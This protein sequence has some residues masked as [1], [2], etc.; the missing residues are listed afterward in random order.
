MKGRDRI[1]KT[2]V[3]EIPDRVPFDGLLPFKSDFFY[4]PLVPSRS[5]QPPDQPGVYPQVHLSM[6]R[7]GLWRWVPQ[8]WTPPKNWM[9]NPR[10][11][12]DEFGCRWEYTANDPSKGHPIGQPLALWD[13]LSTWKFPDP[14]DTTRYHFFIKIA[15]LYPQKYKV[16]LLD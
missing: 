1:R 16:C 14:Y 9:V 10:Q 3:C 7:N 5:W 12:V 13:Q 15:Q 6:L 2:M 4:V 8:T 11:A